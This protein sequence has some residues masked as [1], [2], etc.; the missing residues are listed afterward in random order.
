MRHV[1]AGIDE[2][3]YGPILG[4]LV[5]GCCALEVPEDVGE[6]LW[7]LLRRRV[8]RTRPP[9][10]KAGQLLHVADSKKVYAGRLANLETPVLALARTLSSD[11]ATLDELLACW[12]ATPGDLPWYA[13]ADGERFPVEADAANVAILANGLAAEFTRLGVRPI[14]LAAETIDE[15]AYN[16]LAGASRNKASVLFDV[17]ARHIWRLLDAHADRDD[18]RLTIV[19]DRHGGRSSYAGPLRMMFPDR[20]LAVVAETE[21]R[22]TYELGGATLTF[23]EK[24]DADH[25]PVAAASMLAK[26]VREALVRRLN[27]WFAARVPGV[28]PT[29]GYWTDGLRFLADVRPALPGLGLCEADLRRVR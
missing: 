27:V 20:P 4:P 2:A 11:A 21:G 26:Y 13:A 5:V 8:S 29:A 7:Q 24:G 17:T 19:C 14:T 15:R 28:A 16:R 9:A 25:L 1:I 10:K 23:V 6:D 18:A 22:S 12:G 3:G